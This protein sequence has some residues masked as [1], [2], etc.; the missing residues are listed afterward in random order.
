MKDFTRQ[1]KIG[2]QLRNSIFISKRRIS[3]NKKWLL[4]EDKYLPE[5]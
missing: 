1:E 5:N 3:E 4:K 2:I